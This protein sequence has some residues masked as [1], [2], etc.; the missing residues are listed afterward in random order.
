[1]ML[2]LDSALR[3]LLLGLLVWSLL[4]LFRMRDTGTE[5]IIWT[6]VLMV[7]LSMPLLNHCLPRWVVAVPLISAA[8]PQPMAALRLTG[9]DEI[10]SRLFWL[11]RYGQTCLLGAY[12]L[13][14]VLCFTRLAI[15]LLLSL[16]LYL[17]AVPVE[18][19]W[20]KGR[21]IRANAALKSPA[22]LAGVILLPADYDQWTKAKREAVVAHEEAHIARG[23]FFVQL[24]AS[25]HCSLF[26]FSP[27]AWWLQSK[28][29]ELAE[30]ASDEAA[31]LR[32]QD[33]ATYAEILLEVALRARSSPALV[34]MAKGPFIQQ[35]V[36]RILSD[37]PSKQLSAPLRVLAIVSLTLVALALASAKAAIDPIP[38]IS[39]ADRISPVRADRSTS[40]PSK[41]LGGTPSAIRIRERAIRP[42]QHALEAPDVPQT[43]E[44]E[45]SYNPKALLDPV[46]TPARPF[47]PA[48][49][50]VHAGQTY[51]IRSTERPVADVSGADG[52]YRQV[53]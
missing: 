37:A 42:A 46:Y 51:Y 18:A 39:I 10:S 26:W 40:S 36:E 45:V 47:I 6:A 29:G 17:R 15:G 32:V 30:T 27:F 43:K 3:S 4:K 41:S 5:T 21:R 25:I 34:A 8:P 22:S 14:L 23:D 7:A 12:V 1:M 31:I 20:A 33:R 9:A 44:D 48:S 38:V 16:R 35:R 24:A 13:G 2:L 53:H 50:I 52:G 19:D 11:A 28:L 49:T